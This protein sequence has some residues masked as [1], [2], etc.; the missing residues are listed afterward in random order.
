MISPIQKPLSLSLPNSIFFFFFP[1][2]A[3]HVF[4]LIIRYVLEAVCRVQ[5]DGSEGFCDS[6]SDF[7]VQKCST[8]A[9]E[10]LVP[11]AERKERAAEVAMHLG[12]IITSLL[13]QD[14]FSFALV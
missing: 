7:L 2:V 5:G 14:K 6:L 4:P 12:S 10:A 11:C 13:P 9:E 1:L 3:W 8:C